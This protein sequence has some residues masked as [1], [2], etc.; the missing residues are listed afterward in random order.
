MPRRCNQ[1]AAA[2]A[3][4]GVEACLSEGARV[5]RLWRDALLGCECEWDSWVCGGREEEDTESPIGPS[6]C[7]QRGRESHRERERHCM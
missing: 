3:G 5:T 1:D 7:R 4:H 6:P 2:L